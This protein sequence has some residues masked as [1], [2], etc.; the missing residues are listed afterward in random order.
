M[1][2]LGETRLDELHQRAL[3]I[4]NGSELEAERRERV[5]HDVRVRLRREQE[6][7]RA[8]RESR[9][10]ELVECATIIFD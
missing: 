10:A 8:L 6:E 9:Q 7:L 2:A 1:I 4:D 3:Q 5:S